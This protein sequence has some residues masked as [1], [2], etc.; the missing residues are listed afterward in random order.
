MP[1]AFGPALGRVLSRPAVAAVLAAGVLAAAA[2]PAQAQRRQ[3]QQEQKQEPVSPGFAK[4]A[5][6]IQKAINDAK[7]RANVVAAKGNAAALSA[8]LAA[9]KGMVAPLLAA[10]T[11]PQDKYTAGQF[12]LA[13]GQMAE[14]PALVRQ[15]LATMIESGKAPNNGQ[16]Q[17]FLGQT[18]FQLK[19]YAAAQ[20]AW[21]AAMTAGYRDNDIDALL[22]QSYLSGGQ[23]P[24]G[25][26]VLRRAIDAKAAA[27]TTPPENW[28]RVGLGA[29]YRAKLVDQVAYFSNG[30]ARHYPNK[31]NWAGAITVLRDTA[32]YAPQ[33]NLDLMR[34]MG[35]TDSFM[36]ERDYIEYLEAADPRRFP[37]EVANVIAAGTASGKLKSSTFV[38]EARATATSRAAADRASLPTLERDARAASAS[39]T[40]ATAAAD[41][42]LSYGDA[43][44]AADLYAVA[45]T[46]SGADLP[47]I[48]T[49]L[50]IAQVDKGDYAGAQASFAKVEGPRKPMA[51]LWSIYAAQKAAGK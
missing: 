17:F 3:Q 49:R 18:A 36:E 32:N 40:T 29:A 13:I 33:D 26:D 20:A 38:T 46:K 9:E 39:A 37:G 41:T 7:T 23:V 30:L 14:D 1:R 51:Q 5:A 2:T 27:G 31:Q 16:L 28:Y 19:D 24:Q 12:V 15:G 47:R 44:K 42:F 48:Y 21:Q 35:R 6:P 10:A 45:L 11:T 22:A 8:A 34:L 4:V 25:L 43:A 50:G